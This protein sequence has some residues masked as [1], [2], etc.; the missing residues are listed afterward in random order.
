MELSSLVS[1]SGKHNF[2][3]S[4]VPFLLCLCE[5]VS[6]HYKKIPRT[7]KGLFQLVVLKASVD[8]LCL[9]RPMVRQQTVARVCGR[10]KSLLILSPETKEDKEE[11][12]VSQVH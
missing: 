4:V 6:H 2:Q 1:V 12:R 7:R 9:F 10:K 8:D 5:L 11:N 3:S